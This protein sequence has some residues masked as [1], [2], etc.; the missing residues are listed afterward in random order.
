MYLHKEEPLDEKAMYYFNKNNVKCKIISDF[1]YKDKKDISIYQIFV[2][3]FYL[4]SL[5]D[6][7]YTQR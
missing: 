5:T 4:T 3:V 7:L 2:E 6:Y 1:F